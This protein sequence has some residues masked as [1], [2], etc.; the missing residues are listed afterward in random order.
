L[1]LHSVKFRPTAFAIGCALAFAAAAG[2]QQS[3]TRQ[4][5]AGGTA[6]F[7]TPATASGT[8]T[9]ELDPAFAGG[10]THDGGNDAT[11]SITLNRPVN[12]NPHPGQAHGNGSQRAKSNPEINLSFDG[13]N[14]FQQRFADNGNQF[15]VEP[16]DQ[17]LCA[18]NG[19]VLEST[20]DVLNIFNTS[21]IS[22]LPGAKAVSLNQ[23]YGYPS[24]INRS[25][26][27]FG[28][29]LTDPSC[30]FDQAAQRWFHV[31]LTLDRVGTSSSLSGTNHLDLAVSQS[32]NPLGNWTVYRIPVQDDGSQGTPNHKCAGGP[33]LGDYPHIGAD[34][35][36]IYLT[37]NEFP[38]FAGGFHGAQIYAISKQALVSNASSLNIVQ[39]DTAA[40]S[41]NTASGL[42]GF[43]VWPAISA[44][45]SPAEQGGIEYLLSSLA[46][47]QDSGVS[48][49]LQL[50]S[51]TGTSALLSGGAPSLTSSLVN[52]EAYGIPGRARQPGTGTNGVGKAPGGGNVDWPLGQCLN[53]TACA[54]ALNGAKFPH[55]EVISDLDANDSRMQQVYYAN[56][57]LWASLGTG[58]AF[59]NPQ[60]SSDGLAFFVLHPQADAGTPTATVVGQG[61]VAAPDLD[62][63]YGTVAVT[64][65][66]RGVL[67]FTATGP[68]TYPSVGYTSLDAKIG[69][70][71]IHIST[72]GVGAQDGFSGYVAENFPNPRRPRW[73][74]YGATALDGNSIWFAQEYIG[75][76]CTLAQY[77]APL[78]GR[79]GNTR[80]ALG[81]WDTRITKVTP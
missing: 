79:C 43:T 31:V 25:T 30:Y 68:G 21:G 41:T 19:Y 81:N 9:I 14:F 1:N 47:F 61:Y 78:F 60:A 49:Q 35:N 5:P 67:S 13:L 56:G 18:G 62:V 26:G 22:V 20:N 71:P 16:P 66:G 36:G 45:S 75:Q 8:S 64:E 15:S 11:G 3:Y 27:Q 23:F 44:Q 59:D 77:E 17:G 52:T 42:P 76:S 80:G 70:G 33:C 2:A 65:S 72:P 69:A 4:I 6:N 50:W 73:G 55:T 7:Q 39:Y 63:T 34:A 40:A 51:L 12:P 74:D 10:D 38:F 32:A 37:T 57:K 24:A 29:S 53:D 48:N 46:V 28:P 54:T 58:I